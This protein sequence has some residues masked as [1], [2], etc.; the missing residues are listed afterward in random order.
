M[1][2]TMNAV[3]KMAQARG[4]SLGEI[5]FYRQ[6][7][8][9]LLV[10]GVVAAGPGLGSL[11]SAKFP[12]HVLRAVIGL[13]AMACTFTAVLALPLAEAT[14][15]GFTMPV[16]ATILGALILR[17][18]TGI[19]RWS[20]VVAGFAGVVIVAQPGAANFPIWGAAFG[21]MGAMLTAVVSILLRQISRTESTMTTVFWFSALSLI[22][23]GVVYVLSARGHAP[24]VW[25]L[26]IGVGA[27]GGVAQLAMTSA[28]KFGPVSL[29]APMDYSSLLWATIYGWVIFAVLPDSAT[30]IGAPVIVASGLYIVWREQ[31]RRRT[32][33]RQAIAQGIA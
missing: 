8:A 26:M 1:F 30:W 24:V 28:L 10:G 2:A 31:V 7:I 5:L 13:M 20:A 22:P 14:T 4:A 12:A 27:L 15:L 17:E 18:R 19:H 11:R 29:V 6:F 25:I 33:T 9:A 21:L 3:I 16:F 32:E 23:L